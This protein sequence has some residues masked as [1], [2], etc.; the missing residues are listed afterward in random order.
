M[1]AVNKSKCTH[2][3]GGPGGPADPAFPG[4][5]VGPYKVECH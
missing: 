4:A 5:P 2:T 1:V 3:A